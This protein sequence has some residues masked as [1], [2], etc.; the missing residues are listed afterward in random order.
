MN[1]ADNDDE[2][3]HLYTVTSKPMGPLP[4]LRDLLAEVQVCLLHA[5]GD[6]SQDANPSARPV[7][8]EGEASSI[9]TQR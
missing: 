4:G 3:G 9:T 8:G 1:E 7:L 6:L 2:N 5:A